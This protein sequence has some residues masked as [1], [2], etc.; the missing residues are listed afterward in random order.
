MP[1]AIKTRCAW[2]EGAANGAGDSTGDDV[3]RIT[4]L[5]SSVFMSLTS[6]RNERVSLR[7]EAWRSR[8]V[9]LVQA[10]LQPTRTDRFN[11]LQFMV[12]SLDAVRHLHRG[13]AR[14]AIQMRAGNLARLSVPFRTRKILRWWE[15]A[16]L[17]RNA[18][19]AAASQRRP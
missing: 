11:G 13:R 10:R 12:H 17:R 15:E 9:C 16:R 6:F 4:A 3:A 19:T 18:D 2:G 14:N 1:S 5:W 7:P 8:N